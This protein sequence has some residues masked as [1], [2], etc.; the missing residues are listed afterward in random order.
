MFLLGFIAK[1]PHEKSCFMDF[2]SKLAMIVYLPGFTCLFSEGDIRKDSFSS[3]TL[4]LFSSA[5]SEFFTFKLTR[6]LNTSGFLPNSLLIPDFAFSNKPYFLISLNSGFSSA[7]KSFFSAVRR[8]T[9][10]SVFISLPGSSAY[11]FGIRKDP[12]LSISSIFLFND[13]KPLGV[14]ILPLFKPA[15]D[16]ITGT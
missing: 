8:R 11:A 2:P 14:R 7:L 3:T 15:V 9:L 6:F 10:F 16:L 5:P 1:T 4:N 13:C 12:K